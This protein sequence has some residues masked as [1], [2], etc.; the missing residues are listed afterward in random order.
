ML[1]H[2]IQPAFGYTAESMSGVDGQRNL[3]VEYGSYYF[4]ILVY[5]QDKSVIQ[6]ETYVLKEGV[7]AYTLEYILNTDTYKNEIFNEVILVANGPD[8][9]LVPQKYFKAHTSDSIY[10][11]IHGDQDQVDITFDQVEQWE[12]VNVFGVDK[13]IH[14]FLRGMYPQTK[15]MHFVSLALL[16][17]FKNN[18]EDLD[19]FAKLYFSPNYITIVLI[20]G[21]QLQ[22]AQSL[23][24]ETTED[25][26]YLLLNLFDKHRIDLTDVKTLVSGYID[27]DSAT[28]KELRKYILDI[29]F[30]QVPIQPSVSD[31]YNV[32]ST[33]F[34]TP[35]LHVLQCV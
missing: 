12:L 20:K 8:V 2:L 27:E 11:S 6:I 15:V 21:A 30:E 19:A 24:Y 35:H 25:A 10:E 17:I 4:T 29:D 28:W 31:K 18:L 16:A 26:I 5:S 23:Y 33:H 32:V 14:H 7:D 1:Q 3:C 34:F 13:N 22:F 9:S